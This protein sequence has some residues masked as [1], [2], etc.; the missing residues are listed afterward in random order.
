M[1]NFYKL[2]IPKT[3]S[4]DKNKIKNK[5]VESR[6]TTGS[7]V[8]STSVTPTAARTPTSPGPRRFPELRTFS[9][10]DISEPTGLINKNL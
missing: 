2:N 4:L 8:T 7:L 10:S 6:V 5:P 1:I 3:N 9:Y